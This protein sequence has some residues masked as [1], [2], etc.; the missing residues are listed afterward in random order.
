MPAKTFLSSR[1]WPLVAFSALERFSRS[2]PPS[3]HHQY[4]PSCT[5]CAYR[6]RYRHPS[7]D[8]TQ[9]LASSAETCVRRPLLRSSS[10]P[11]AS[12]LADTTL[13]DRHHSL[14]AVRSAI[15]AD[16]RPTFA[17]TH[18]SY[19]DAQ[20]RAGLSTASALSSHHH[21]HLPSPPP[22][23]PA[24][25]PPDPTTP[26]L[27]R[28]SQ[29][30]DRIV[31]EPIHLM[32]SAISRDSPVSITANTPSATA[33]TTPSLPQ[34]VSSQPAVKSYANATKTATPPTL[35][36]AS[37]PAHNAAKPTDAQLNGSM[38]QGGSQQAHSGPS[39]GTPATMDHSRK[40]SV[41][42]NASGASGSYPN[43]GP[44]GQ[45]GNRPAINFGSMHAQGGEHGSASFPAQNA[46]LQQPR[47]DPRATTPAHSP[48]PIPQPAASGG[49]PPSNLPNQHNGGLAFGSLLADSETVSDNLA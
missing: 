15:C 1:V 29:P 6:P 14:A 28:R 26:K 39:N 45:N 43:G 7:A 20:R 11:R 13:A 18:D 19:C 44:V 47:Q 5:C 30:G 36:G 10:P 22:L 35:A 24:P 12:A 9:F 33:S 2:L 38:A 17:T 37:A 4:T 40:P 32:T 16:C 31:N 21:H 34:A 42:I 23:P 41:V 48:S 49:R 27:F 8:P 25:F 3:L 46:S